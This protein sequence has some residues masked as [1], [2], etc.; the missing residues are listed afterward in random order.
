MS[1]DALAALH[2]EAFAPHRGWSAA[3][4]EALL[5]RPTTELIETFD[6]FLIAQIIPP[7]AE[8]LTIAVARKARRRGT[9]QALVRDLVWRDDLRAVFLEVA[10]DNTPARAL[11]AGLGFAVTGRRAGYYKRPTGPVDAVLM[12]WAKGAPPAG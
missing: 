12:R 9:A 5:A 2:A 11:Y 10:A 1:P 7:E 4:F 8:I 6:G 3:E